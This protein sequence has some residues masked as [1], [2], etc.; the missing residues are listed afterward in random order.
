MGKSVI[1]GRSVSVI[2]CVSDFDV[3]KGHNLG[4]FSPEA[5][6]KVAAVLRQNDVNVRFL[7][8]FTKDS[9]RI[10]AK[11]EKKLVFWE[12]LMIHMQD[13]FQNNGRFRCVVS[14]SRLCLAC[15]S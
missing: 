13:F 9:S 11:T 5:R 6:D 2:R 3:P 8:S 10:L 12:K 15:F 4:C 14:E 7:G 1:P